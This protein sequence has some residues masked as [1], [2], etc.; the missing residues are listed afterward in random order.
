MRKLLA[1][2]REFVNLAIQAQPRKDQATAMKT[3][4]M[5]PPTTRYMWTSCTLLQLAWAVVSS[6]RN[7]GDTVM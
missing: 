3:A 4:E 1:S 2:A 5:I 7:P 6:F